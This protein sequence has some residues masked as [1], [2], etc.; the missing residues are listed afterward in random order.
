MTYSLLGIGF[1][2]LVTFALYKI[3]R[4]GIGLIRKGF[5]AAKQTASQP[6]YLNPDPFPREAF[7]SYSISQNEF[8]RIAIKT[9]Y[10]HQ[11]VENAEVENNILYIE[12]SSQSGLS[13]NHAKLTFTLTGSS[14]GNYSLGT[15]N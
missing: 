3:I 6:R 7:P 4:F 5:R 11:R 1:I 9:A 12:F 14:I 13:K 10:R 8:S 2:F 15:D